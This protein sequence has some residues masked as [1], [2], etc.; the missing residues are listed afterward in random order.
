MGPHAKSPAD[1]AN[2]PVASGITAQLYGGGSETRIAQEF[3][4]GI[5]GWR[6][7]KKLGIAPEVCHLNEGH[8]A[9]AVLER[10]ADFMEITG[11]TFEVALQT[12]RAGSGR[13]VVPA[14]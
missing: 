2:P 7:L 1:P 13:R 9:F 12:T 3:I 10:A 6:L 5:G 14:G 4:L 11:C 8:A